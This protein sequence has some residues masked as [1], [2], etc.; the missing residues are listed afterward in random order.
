MS[1]FKLQAGAEIDVLTKDELRP[2]LDDYTKELG[3]GVR[4]RTITMPY[5]L[6]GALGSQTIT[7]AATQMNKIGPD[8]GLIWD[9]RFLIV[10][11]TQYFT[12][13]VAVLKNNDSGDF[14]HLIT[15]N[16]S[17]AGNIVFSSHSMILHS[18]E[19]LTLTTT[20]TLN[21]SG[22]SNTITLTCNVVEVPSEREGQLLL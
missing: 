10:T 1:K 6:H 15:S 3:R 20:N 9:V 11:C 17:W 18:N 8:S 13:T 4:F 5:Q 22:A 2:I 7:P 16:L 21:L 19:Y 12:G 14:S